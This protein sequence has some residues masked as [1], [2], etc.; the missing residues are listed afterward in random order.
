MNKKLRRKGGKEKKE[1]IGNIGK[2]NRGM[3]LEYQVPK[4]LQWFQA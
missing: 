4:R 3:N 1:G 2:R